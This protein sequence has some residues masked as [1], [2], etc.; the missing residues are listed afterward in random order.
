M[1]NAWKDVDVIIQA[2]RSMEAFAGVRQDE[3]VPSTIT[4]RLTTA[5]EL[6]N[7][8]SQML[9][10]WMQGLAGEPSA[11]PGVPPGPAAAPQLRVSRSPTSSL[12]DQAR[13]RGL[14]PPP[15]IS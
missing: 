8:A 6:V 4:Q 5:A 12:S 14:P 1:R 15:F 3:L 9:G 13:L 11:T 10:Q 7:E 2:S